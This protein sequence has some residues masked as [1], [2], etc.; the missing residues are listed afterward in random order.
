[1]IQTLLH[2]LA[3]LGR[4]PAARP[5]RPPRRRG[6]PRLEILED[7]AVPA[8]GCAVVGGS[9]YYD[10]NNNGIRD[11]GEVGIANNPVALLDAGT[12]SVVATTT[13]DAN[14]YYTFDQDGRVDTT[15]QTLTREVTFNTTRTNSTQTLTVEQFNAD[16]G[17]LTSVDILFDGK[18][19]SQVKVESLDGSP[20]T[21][22]VETAAS[23]DLTLNHKDS[24]TLGAADGQSDFAGPAGKDFGAKTATGTKTVTLK[25]ND[26]AAFIGTGRVTL[27]AT[28]KGSSSVSGPG[29][30]LSQVSTTT[31]GKVTVVYHYTPEDCLRPGRYVVRQLEQPAGYLTGLNTNDNVRPIPGSVGSFEIPVVVGPNGRSENNHFGELVPSTLSGHVYVDANDNGQLDAGERRLPG[32][33]VRLTGPDGSVRTTT[34]DANGFYEFGGLRAGNYLIQE[35]QPA[36]YLDGKEHLGTEGGVVANDQFFLTLGVAREGRDYDFGELIPSTLS[37]HVYHDADND[38]VRDPG[39]APIP[40]TTVRLTGPDGSVRTTTT[41]SNGFYEF[42]GLRPGNYLIVE[43]QPAGYDDGKERVGTQGGVV[44]ANDQ[45]FLT[46]AMGV[47]GRDY[48]F[49]EL[50]TQPPERPPVRPP[51]LPPPPPAPPPAPPQTPP[52]QPPQMP[53]PSKRSLIGSVNMSL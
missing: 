19:V 33:T 50:L 43:Q 48:D 27:T 40:G 28:G 24:A 41:D 44:V 38:G 34:T 37:G 15:P 7:R 22:T 46:L 6:S 29:N 32:V 20:S 14:G 23:L 21:V 30:V 3:R 39:E 47:E 4:R 51:E 17:T 2:L 13:T 26:L 8:T 10:A 5:A 25:G 36:G 53:T 45:F 16:L 18:L 1:M 12:G 42:G 49:G 35:E 52:Q 11:S 31:S 9:V